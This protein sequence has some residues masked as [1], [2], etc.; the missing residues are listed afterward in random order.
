MV[1]VFNSAL[2]YENGEMKV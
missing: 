1:P 2:G